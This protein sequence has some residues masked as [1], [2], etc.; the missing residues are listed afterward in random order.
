[1]KE[2]ELVVLKI[3]EETTIHKETEGVHSDVKADSKFFTYEKQK[4]GDLQMG[5]AQ[6]I[7]EVC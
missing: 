2:G 3:H 7:E 6:P 5:F 4:N 1:V